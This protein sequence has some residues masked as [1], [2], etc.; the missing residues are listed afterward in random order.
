[1]DQEVLVQALQVEVLAKVVVELVVGPLV[2][3][4]PNDSVID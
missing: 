1:M 4:S 3:P 2:R